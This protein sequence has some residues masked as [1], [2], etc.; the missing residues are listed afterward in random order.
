M[1][2]K[3]LIS[4]VFLVA[5]L[6]RAGV[7]KDFQNENIEV[8][9]L[10]NTYRVALTF[11]DG[12][13]K[14]TAKILDLLNEYNIKATFFAVAKNMKSNPELTNRIVKEGHILANHSYDH[15]N[16][17]KQVYRD[18]PESLLVE[19]EE[20]HK[21]ILKYA[22]GLKKYYFR[23][24]Y[25]AW[26][27]EHGNYLNQNSEM[28]KYVGPIC[29]DVGRNIEF[30]GTQVKNAADW[31]CWSSKKYPEFK[32]PKKCSEGYLS[33][34]EEYKGGVVLMHD[35]HAKT[36]DM[37]EILIPMLIAKKYQFINLDQIP[38]LKNYGKNLS[39]V[40]KSV[41]S[42]YSKF[43]GR[44]DTLNPNLVLSD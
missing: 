3:I 11:D 30:D 22:P 29:W 26:S 4:S 8:F 20:T 2:K 39:S 5:A 18:H 34:L 44:C 32:E 17:A 43:R 36:A 10:D 40:K 33:K 41:S 23:A 9:N 15:D 12:P 38:E 25:S 21:E 28:K 6:S 19:I 37:L 35:I 24:P 13:G 16:L 1:V 27:P 7:K 31:E 42:A 14:G